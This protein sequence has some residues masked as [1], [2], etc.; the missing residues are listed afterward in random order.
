MA[1]HSECRVDVE[2]RIYKTAG[3]RLTDRFKGSRL[4]GRIGQMEDVQKETLFKET[5][6]HKFGSRIGMK[7]SGSESEENLEHS[8]EVD[9]KNRTDTSGLVICVTQQTSFPAKSSE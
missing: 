4:E 2:D 3:R 7:Q 5:I 6:N 9:L 1:R 8:E